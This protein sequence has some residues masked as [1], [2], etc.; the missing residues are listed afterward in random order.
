M[1]FQKILHN[2]TINENENSVLFTDPI[3]WSIRLM[4]KLLQA[5][6]HG[7]ILLVFFS[8]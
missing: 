6:D 8:F 3:N 7:T 2:Y 4:A 5:K 1:W